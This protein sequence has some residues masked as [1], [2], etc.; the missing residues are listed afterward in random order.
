M[1]RFPNQIRRVSS[2]AVLVV[3]LAGSA[4]A[5]VSPR[6]RPTQPPSTIKQ[7]LVWIF[8]QVSVPKGEPTGG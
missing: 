6:N 2:A 7:I 1:R 4:N 3:L 8:D 5:A